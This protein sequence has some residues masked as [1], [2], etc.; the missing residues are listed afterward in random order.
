[1]K[2]LF[3]FLISFNVFAGDICNP[4]LQF[5]GGSDYNRSILL[6]VQE[7]CISGRPGNREIAEIRILTQLQTGL[8]TCLEE[9]N[10]KRVKEDF[11]GELLI[12]QE[13]KK[14]KFQAAIER[15]RTDERTKKFFTK[16]SGELE[17]QVRSY[18]KTMQDQF[19]EY[20]R[21]LR[22][23]IGLLKS[24]VDE[25]KEIKKDLDEYKKRCEPQ[26]YCNP[27]TI[28]DF[29]ERY[30]IQLESIKELERSIQSEERKLDPQNF[31]KRVTDLFKKYHAETKKALLQKALDDPTCKGLQKQSI[32]ECAK[33][34]DAF[35]ML[36]QTQNEEYEKVSEIYQEFDKELSE[37]VDDNELLE[38]MSMAT[39]DK[40]RR[41]L[42]VNQGDD[43]YMLDQLYKQMDESLL[44]KYIDE[45]A[46][47][48][49]CAAKDDQFTCN[50]GESKS[51]EV[52]NLESIS[53]QLKQKTQTIRSR[54]S[55][56]TTR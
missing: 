22:Y 14:P 21:L 10:C 15:L 48:A 56:S 12:Q 35:R 9:F 26:N 55:G 41:E 6:A 31:A 40:V 24:K 1:M 19:E 54:K 18:Q 7:L 8:K 28:K 11:L 36:V 38:L 3:L 32:E 4:D 33:V 47:A 17:L 53:K 39:I 37:K 29:E 52:S 51:S 5:G 45:K 34:S 20:K 13:S 49:A 30:N 27:D 2:F 50:L 23:N 25:A 42:G 16:G 44:G 46:M 43:R